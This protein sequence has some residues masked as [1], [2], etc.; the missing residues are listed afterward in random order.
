MFFS[1]SGSAFAEN[2]EI[3][4]DQLN[5]LINTI[6]TLQSQ[7]NKMQNKIDKIESRYEKKVN[8]LQGNI[9][10]FISLGVIIPLFDKNSRYFGDF[11]LP[12]NT[13]YLITY[14]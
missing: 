2:V 9:R 10:S 12:D 6:N 5:S 8:Q 4:K 13:G 14:C 3:S 1:T 7:L 11:F